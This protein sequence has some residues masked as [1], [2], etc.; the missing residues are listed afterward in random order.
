MDILR[1]EKRLKKKGVK[2]IAGIDEVGRGPLAGPVMACA[3]VFLSNKKI[4]KELGYIIT[5]LTLYQTIQNELIKVINLKNKNKIINKIIFHAEN[6]A[7]RK[8]KIVDF[9]MSNNPCYPYPMVENMLNKAAPELKASYHPTLITYDKQ[10]L[11][12]KDL[13]NIRENH[14]FIRKNLRT[15]LRIHLCFEELSRTILLVAFIFGL[16]LESGKMFIPGV[17]VLLILTKSWFF[18]KIKGAFNF[19]EFLIIHIYDF[20]ALFTGVFLRSRMHL[21]KQREKWT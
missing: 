21:K 5:K 2:I 16:T 11:K 10:S 12:W 19:R 3:L 14:L 7:F 13:I 6:I 9:F 20:A 15:R 1:E 4:P 8:K 18:Y 17:V